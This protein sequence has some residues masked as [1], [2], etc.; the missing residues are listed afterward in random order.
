MIF[1]LVVVV[2]N[3]NSAVADKRNNKKE[4][5]VGSFL[6]HIMV[7]LFILT[8]ISSLHLMPKQPVGLR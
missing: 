7:R 3:I 5:P 4:V 2:K 1:V 6:F 8:Q